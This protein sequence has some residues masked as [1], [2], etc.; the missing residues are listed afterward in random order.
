MNCGLRSPYITF[1]YSI[2]CL[3]LLKYPSLRLSSVQ[4]ISD[5]FPATKKRSMDGNLKLK[6]VSLNVLNMED[7]EQPSSDTLDP[8]LLY[9]K[10][11]KYSQT[12]SFA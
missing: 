4:H 7:V 10:C 5:A 12:A 2:R 1:H 8:C 11:I 3:G 6:N 9:I